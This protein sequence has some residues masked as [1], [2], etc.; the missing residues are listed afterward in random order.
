[1]A[2]K[3]NELAW[4]TDEERLELGMMRWSEETQLWLF[5]ATWYDQIPEG[6]E[7]IT[8][9]KQIRKFKHGK[10]DRDQR[11]GMLAYGIVARRIDLQ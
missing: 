4:L 5:P 2:I 11:F 1:M 8:I 3:F 6:F 10:A 7:V 9:N